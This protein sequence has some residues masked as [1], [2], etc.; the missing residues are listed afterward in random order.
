MGSSKHDVW[1]W[2]V[3][4]MVAA[5]RLSGHEAAVNCA[6]I[7][8]DG[9]RIVSGSRDQTVRYGMHEHALLRQ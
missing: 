1:V 2:E 6:A 7:A 9:H 5:T 4:N 3:E 8:P